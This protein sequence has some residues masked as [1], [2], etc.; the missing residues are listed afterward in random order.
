MG[1]F[2]DYPNG[3]SVHVPD[4]AEGQRY[5][6]PGILSS[7]YSRMTLRRQKNLAS[8]KLFLCCGR[9]RA[10]HLIALVYGVK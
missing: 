10:A 1:S 5:S 3:P 6:L 2:D 9:F 8:T 7:A 4:L